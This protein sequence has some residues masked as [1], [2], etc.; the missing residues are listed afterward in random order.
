MASLI[1]ESEGRCSRNCA[2]LRVVGLHD[3]SELNYTSL[4]G[5]LKAQDR[6]I[7]QLDQTAYKVGFFLHP[8][9]VLE[10]QSGVPLGF[11]S[12]N[13]Y[14]RPFFSEPK[15]HLNYKSR[16]IEEKESYKWLKSAYKS[17]ETL[18]S[19]AHTLLISDRESDIY[20]Y[21]GSVPDVK[22]DVLLRIK[23]DRKVNDSSATQLFDALDG[24]ELLGG[25]CLP[26]KNNP[27]RKS[28]IAN[29]LIR[30]C[31]VDIKRPD[32]APKHLP[33]TTKGYAIDIREIDESVPDNERPIHWRL[34]TTETVTTLEDALEIARLYTMRWQVEQLFRTI[35]KKGL[36]LEDSQLA[37]GLKLKKLTVIALQAALL[38]MTLVQQR[39]QEND[40]KASICFDKEQIQFLKQLIPI[41]EGKT[42]KQKN[43]HILLS[44]PWAAWAIA[45]LGG[46]KGFPS[47]SPP[48]IV[49]FARG[50]GKFESQFQGWKI[51]QMYSG[52]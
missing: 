40:L 27:K 43:P 21:I 9:L 16:P 31:P 19:A 3:T 18:S 47:E 35:K 15:S 25:I 45:R 38:I 20:D 49:S 29:L 6:D 41:L 51:A 33:P 44:L 13:F 5:K 11:S 52:P 50:V 48:G 36:K 34:F 2:G 42:Q 26:I 12:I 32:S 10:R 14:A 23:V 17:K 28:R 39:D 46:W 4:N 24:A 22:T 37:T 7:G 8:S 30:V 1:E